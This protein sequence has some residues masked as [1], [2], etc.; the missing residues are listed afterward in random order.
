MTAMPKRARRYTSGDKAEAIM[1]KG[2]GWN[3]AEI[4][5]LM[6]AAGRPVT[7][8]AV[9]LWVDD[10]AAEL[11]RARDRRYRRRKRAQTETFAWPG[12]VS[13]GWKLRRMRALSE[14]GVSCSAIAALMTFDFP[15]DPQLSAGQVRYAIATGTIPPPLREA[16]A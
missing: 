1:L 5:R 13:G 8:T 16:A 11:Q 12:R 4:T 9:R 10:E 3:A 2:G 14:A 7:Y 6:Q 15:D